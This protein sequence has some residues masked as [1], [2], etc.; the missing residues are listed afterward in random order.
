MLFLFN[1]IM[2]HSNTQNV[3]ALSKEKEMEYKILEVK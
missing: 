3:I 1:L 2:S